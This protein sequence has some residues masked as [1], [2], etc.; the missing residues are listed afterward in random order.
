MFCD[1]H[2]GSTL[3]MRLTFQNA[4]KIPII[5]TSAIL[6]EITIICTRN[7]SLQI[8]VGPSWLLTVYI[9]PIRDS[10]FA[11]TKTCISILSK[12]WST[13]TTNYASRSLLAWRT[14]A[15]SSRRWRHLFHAPTKFMALQPWSLCFDNANIFSSAFS[16]TKPLIQAS[17]VEALDGRVVDKTLFFSKLPR[18]VSLQEPC[19]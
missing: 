18:L 2:K 17:F 5:A 4:T 10:L 14:L 11:M 3:Q 8:C 13:M 19:R 7:A 16:S 9:S 15:I 6:S 12:F 1:D